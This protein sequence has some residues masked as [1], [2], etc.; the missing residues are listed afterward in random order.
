MNI[1]ND[2]WVESDEALFNQKTISEVLKISEAKLERDRW[3]GNGIPFLK[4]GR[5]VRYRKGDVTKWLQK[6]APTV[7]STTQHK[8]EIKLHD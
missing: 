3:L 5:S 4:L 1:I 2:F 7:T 8:T 6:H